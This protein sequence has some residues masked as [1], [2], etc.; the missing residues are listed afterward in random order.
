MSDLHSRIHG[1]E[2]VGGEPASVHPLQRLSGSAA[3]RG[4]AA[5]RQHRLPQRDPL[6]GLRLRR[7][8]RREQHDHARG[9]LKLHNIFN[10]LLMLF[11]CRLC[12]D[13]IWFTEFN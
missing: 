11:L 7:P 6:E 3:T 4:H 13:L 10:Y 1:A 8:H 2:P 9:Y 12:W 5:G